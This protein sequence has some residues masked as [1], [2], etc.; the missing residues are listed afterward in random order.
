MTA[1]MQAGSSLLATKHDAKRA[2]LQQ[3]CRLALSEGKA[4]N[5]CTQHGIA[6]VALTIIQGPI[7]Q[8]FDAHPSEGLAQRI[9]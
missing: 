9:G 6:S 1:R 8:N 4:T 3:D 5:K 7:L 2:D